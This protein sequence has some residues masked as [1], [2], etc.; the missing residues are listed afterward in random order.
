MNPNAQIPGDL[1]SRTKKDADHD[2][3]AGERTHGEVDTAEQ[4]GEGLPQRNEPEGRASEHHR[5]DVEIPEV[6]FVLRQ[7]V[8]AEGDHHRSENDHRGVVALDESCEP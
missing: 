7:D 2:E 4:Q 6:A 3:E 1:P 8:R 5:G